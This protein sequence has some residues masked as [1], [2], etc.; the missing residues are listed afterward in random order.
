E[1]VDAANARVKD[2]SAQWW[3][4]QGAAWTAQLNTLIGLI[5][6]GREPTDGEVQDMIEG[7]YRWISQ[8]WKP[9]RESYTGLGDLYADDPRFRANFDKSDPRLA[10][11]LR[12]AIAEY[13]RTRL[14]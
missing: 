10:E 2:K 5:D 3:Q 1:Q 11:F 8:H 12:A 7:H 14:D 13:A 9:N 4:E 6:A